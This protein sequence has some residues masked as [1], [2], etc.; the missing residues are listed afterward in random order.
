MQGTL[1]RTEAEP[2]GVFT[3]KIDHIFIDL[4]G[5]LADWV[6]GVIDLFGR[7][8]D[9]VFR[10][11]TSGDYSVEKALNV[12]TERLWNRINQQGSDWWAHLDRFHWNQDLLSL[13]IDTTAAASIL[14][15]PGDCVHA[16]NGK[17]IW[18]DR[19][20]PGFAL[21]LTSEK[22]LLAKPSSLLIDDSGRNCEEFIAAGGNAILFPQHWNDHW[23]LTADRIDFVR[24]QLREFR[25]I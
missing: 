22:Q 14:T 23:R 9:Y 19:H 13:I 7:D 11:W 5:V 16:Y 2:A 8:R 12:T 6:G 15:S 18:A 20:V 24:E 10:H 21:H 3:G 17:R 25:V 4:D 1:T